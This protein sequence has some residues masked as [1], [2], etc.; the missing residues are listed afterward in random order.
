LVVTG[1]T[2]KGQV[3]FYRAVG[4]GNSTWE[5]PIVVRFFDNSTKLE[6]NWSPINVT[7]DAYGNFAIVGIVSGTYDIGIKNYTTLSEMVYGENFTAGSVTLINFGTLIE[8]DCD[9]SDR[10]DCS[11][12]SRVLNNYGVMEVAD[13]D[14]WMMY[15]MWKAD[16]NRDKKIDGSDYSAVLNNYGGRGDIFYYTH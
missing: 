12:Y 6:M 3:S 10:T 2:L 1:A 5:T 15:E 16:Y 4:H 8:A 7:T 14:W 9:D 13:P 11:D